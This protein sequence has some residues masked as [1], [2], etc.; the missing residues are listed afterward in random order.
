MKIGIVG[1][2][3][4]G[5]YLVEALHSMAKHKQLI[6]V[7][8]ICL[9]DYDLVDEKVLKYQNFHDEEILEYKN[10]AL[11]DR[12][13]YT[14]DYSLFTTKIKKIE[15]IEDLADFDL[16]ISAVDGSSFRKLLFKN[17]DK[18][19]YWIDL[20]SEGRSI[21]Y[22]TKHEKNTQ[23][24]L[25]GSIEEGREGGSCQLAYELN[26]NIIQLGNRIIGPIGAQLLVNHLRGEQNTSSYTRRF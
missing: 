17:E 3:G 23:K 22:Y 9:I 2:G 14:L 6:N 12:Y 20:R 24:V 11:S 13:N 19:T 16:I 18:F 15:D 7:E 4:I 26:N 10:V 8:S 5:S 21:A 25:L 1:C